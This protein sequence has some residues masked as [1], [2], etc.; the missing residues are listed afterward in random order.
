MS[1]IPLS[2]PAE[3]EANACLRGRTTPPPP[4]SASAPVS[5]MDLDGGFFAEPLMDFNFPEML[6]GDLGK[7]EAIFRSRNL[8]AG[9]PATELADDGSKRS[10][11]LQDGSER[12]LQSL[13]HHDMSQA[14]LLQTPKPRASPPL[15]QPDTQPRKS[16]ESLHSVDSD[17]SGAMEPPSIR[18][19]RD[20]SAHPS[21][22]STT[23]AMP[24]PVVKH[25]SDS[26]IDLDL[27]DIMARD[28][29][30]SL[31]HISLQPPL[32]LAQA[33]SPAR[34]VNPDDFRSMSLGSKL[35][36]AKPNGLYS[37]LN[38]HPKMPPCLARA[39]TSPI[40]VNQF[41]GGPL[42]QPAEVPT[43][44]SSLRA[45]TM[46]RIP[47]IPIP[48]P[49]RTPPSPDQPDNGNFAVVSPRGPPTPPEKEF[50]PRN[51]QESVSAFDQEDDY[52]DI[53]DFSSQDQGN[54]LHIVSSPKIQ[55]E[56]WLNSSMDLGSSHKR[57]P[58]SEFGTRIPVPSEV[59]DTLRVS[60]QC[61]P[62]TMLL[63]SSFSIETLR[64]HS[65][66]FKYGTVDLTSESEVSLALPS[67]QSQRPSKWKWLTTKRQTDPTSPKNQP[68]SQPY[69]EAATPTM[70]P[71]RP[72]DS[73]W[74]AI[75]KIFPQGSDYLCDA[76]YAHIVAYN[77]ITSLCPRTPVIIPPSTPRP[78]SR[79]S[80]RPKSMAVSRPASRPTSKS[81]YSS[82]TLSSDLSPARSRAS[83][84]TRVPR[85]A[86]SILGMHTETTSPTI[87]FPEFPSAAGASSRTSTM[88]SNKR[89]FAASRRPTDGT[90]A[91]CSAANRSA[92]DHDASLKELRLGLARC[93]ARLVATLRVTSSSYS[94]L[95][96][97]DGSPPKRNVSVDPFFIRSLCELV[98]ACEEGDR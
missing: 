56:E 71:V 37:A 79:P 43:R 15:T 36:P 49:T 62:E 92:D 8:T 98:R 28:R 29:R 66:K 69:P 57:H 46:P 13:A 54:G 20:V 59:L 96:S 67:S 50:Q 19:A 14:Q 68:R 17:C 84:S 38:A 48:M 74:R 39:I 81:S 83:D 89:S 34:T 75:R 16:S 41:P 4:S 85:K 42:I 78:A 22:S 86:A 7:S 87:P 30:H 1:T 91:F 60:V 63:C 61:F 6:A 40:V 51:S 12:H 94:E 70:S 55:I 9:A 76:L 52:Q 90:K 24:I 53:A 31:S 88:A 95:G 32:P 2:V 97:P 45:T 82:S 27:D 23:S 77:Y 64:G 3:S 44:R 93:V 73:D 25:A 11:S 65:R 5:T 35:S 33:P 26:W 47:D 10:Y 18:T 72:G 21:H 80:S 58:S